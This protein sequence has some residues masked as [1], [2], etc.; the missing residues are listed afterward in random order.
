MHFNRF[1]RDLS[2]VHESYRNLR[3]L[4]LTEEESPEKDPNRQPLNQGLTA[5]SVLN[6]PC[7]YDEDCSNSAY[8]ICKKGE[9]K[10]KNLQ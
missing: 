3:V 8:I 1:K 10:P 7:V 6:M 5:D 2:G 4:E 9:P